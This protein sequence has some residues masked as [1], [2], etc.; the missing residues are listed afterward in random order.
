[1]R[2]RIWW[3]AAAV[4]MALWAAPTGADADRAIGARSA[5]A[6][7][8]FVIV[9]P[10]LLTLTTDSEGRVVARSNDGPL[11][12]SSRDR[13]RIA[14]GVTPRLAFDRLQTSY[15]GGVIAAP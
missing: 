2:T 1:M 10:R 15:Q 13:T 9:I 11:V 6:S 4:G 3:A 14:M 8:R 5:S 7:V 12:H